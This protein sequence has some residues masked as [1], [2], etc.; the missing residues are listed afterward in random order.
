[1]DFKYLIS[2]SKYQ[3]D[4]I[5]VFIGN[6][7]INSSEESHG[8]NFKK[9]NQYTILQ[10]TMVDTYLDFSPSSYGKE[11]IYFTDCK[12]A[13][14]SDFSD[15]NFILLDEYRSEKLKHILK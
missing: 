4:V 10:K 2:E 9:G 7:Y 12:Y 1:M 13:C 5:L 3:K 8:S 14:F 15:R 11:I 6:N